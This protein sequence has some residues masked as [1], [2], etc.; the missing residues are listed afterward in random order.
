MQIYE[1]K[2]LYL[3]TNLIHR[4]YCFL[5]KKKLMYMNKIVAR[6]RMNDRC[7]ISPT[8]AT[9][10]GTESVYKKVFT[11][12]TQFCT[13]VIELSLNK[14]CNS[15]KYGCLFPDPLGFNI[16]FA[17]LISRKTRGCISTTSSASS[18]DQK[19]IL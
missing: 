8:H 19:C 17:Q 12:Y 14:I 15:S 4:S 16:Y 6:L 9:Y 18:W 2:I 5:E 13:N 7:F 10:V 1:D 11:T 3:P